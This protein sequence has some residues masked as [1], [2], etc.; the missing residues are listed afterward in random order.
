MAQQL[1]RLAHVSQS[2]FAATA[3][4]AYALAPA[5]PAIAQQ[6]ANAQESA[7]AD[8]GGLEE[9]V[10][11]AQKR[12][13]R[14]QDV[15]VSV[16]AV[17]GAALQNMGV[18]NFEN[19]EVPGVR[20]SRGGMADTITVRGIGSGQNLGFEQSAPMY[21]DGIYHGRARTQRLGFL[22]VERVELLKGPQPTFL[23]K[24]AIAGAINIT[25]RKPGRDFEGEA[26]ASYEPVTDEFSLFGAVSVP[27]SETI[28]MRGALKYRNSEGYLTNTI[29]GRREPEIKDL[30]GR[31]T[32][33]A[34]VTD[35]VKATL[36]GYF[37]NN[38]DRGRNNQSTVC[39]P[40]FRRDISDAV[41]EPC[42]F[43]D[44]KASSGV[45]PASAKAAYPGIY[46]DDSGGP[47]LN[48]L[49]A[50]GT[51]L[52]LDSEIGTSGLTLTSLTG[53]YQYKNYQFIDTDQGIA[54]FATATFNERYRQFS[55]EVRLV[56]PNTG[57]LKW[58][59]GAYLDNNRN[60]A[61]STS[62]S[63]G[64][65]YLPFTPPAVAPQTNRTAAFVNQNIFNQVID[66]RENA[67]SWAVFGEAN[68]AFTDQFSAR[69]GLRYE[70]V[71]KDLPVFGFCQVQGQPY[72]LCNPT[73]P[74]SAI[75]SS[76]KDTKLQPAVTFEYRP[77]D[78]V[79]FYGS[80]K[81]GFKAGGFSNTE[82]T[83]F[84]PENVSAFE[85][86]SK[87]QFFDNRVILNLAAFRGSY[88]DLQVSS[89]DPVTNQFR[90]NNAA[91]ART[92]GVETELQWAV[93]PE[94]R[95]S[96]NVA[97]LDAKYTRFTNAQCWAGQATLGTGC[98]T[99]NG[100]A[101]QDLSGK[102][103]PYAPKWSGTVSANYETGLTAGLV[104]RLGTDVF[105]TSQFNTLSDINPRAAQDGFAKINA[106]IAIGDDDD[107]WEVAVIGR[108]LT[109]KRT[110]AFKNT[111]PGGFFSIAS[112]TEPPATYSL[113][114]R[115]KF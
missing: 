29:T 44:K 24:N 75:V 12:S 94:L 47:F 86:G 99:V 56:S 28:S 115:V 34:D 113:Q 114:A 39:E 77:V 112:F 15:P 11:T 43:D 68:Y 63:D 110:A 102:E 45:I 53:Y 72:V 61:F 92:Q 36:I 9:I 40:N 82:G 73:R 85:V 41:R 46:E 88:K 8:S 14:L 59:L 10:I 95:L 100:V 35:T 104:G 87:T 42:L 57:A 109:D 31:L 58:F 38:T 98:V 22:D 80:Y 106:R 5:V 108:N 16:Q 103:T 79:L 93:T 55:Q 111:I 76:R 51:T 78:R 33:V 30:L 2:C 64:R 7:D 32:F 19:F 101:S 21:I 84:A 90:T 89:F 69:A 4:L 66:F 96:G 70:E 65:N 71:T 37:G 17:T 54:N 3:V 48:R 83:P 49:R 1:K 91:A 23:G 13:E 26:E 25:T 107:R 67:K 60:R 81:R 18:Q 6:A 62:D 27:V 97:Y 52:Q 50:K 20:V 105:F 74:A